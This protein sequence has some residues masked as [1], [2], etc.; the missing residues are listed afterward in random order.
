MTSLAS[1]RPQ[2]RWATLQEASDYTA[3]DDGTRVAVRTLRRWVS[4]GTL[5]GYRI[6]PRAIRVD[7]NDLDD[8]LRPIPS[9]EGRRRRS[10]R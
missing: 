10:R 9:A 4:E 2:P 5:P 7:L 1:A 6:G 8:I 3:T